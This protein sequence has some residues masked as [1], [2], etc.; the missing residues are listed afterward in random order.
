M[1]TKFDHGFDQAR[2][3]SSLQQGSGISSDK[4]LVGCKTAKTTAYVKLSIIKQSATI[5]VVRD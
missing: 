1:Q 2:K 3:P 4:N 5:R